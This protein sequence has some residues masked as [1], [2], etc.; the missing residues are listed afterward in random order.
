[1]TIV[2]AIVIHTRYNR[3]NLDAIATADLFK[4][5]GYLFFLLAHNLHTFRENIPA[6]IYPIRE[7]HRELIAVSDF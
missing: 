2:C 6:I 4:R 1:M 3:R 7:Y 5:T